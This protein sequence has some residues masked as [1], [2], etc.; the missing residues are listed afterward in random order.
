[1]SV[2]YKK[3]YKIWLLNISLLMCCYT[4]PQAYAQDNDKR[5][6][7]HYFL[8]HCRSAVDASLSSNRD[9]KLSLQG[10]LDWGYHIL[11]FRRFQKGLLKDQTGYAEPVG[12]DA[13]NT[14]VTLGVGI[15][16]PEKQL[17]YNTS[18]FQIEEQR[19]VVPIY[20]QCIWPDFFAGG[21]YTVITLGLQNKYLMA[22]S[23]N[24]TDSNPAIR[25]TFH[26][27]AGNL[28]DHCDLKSFSHSVCVSW[29]IMFT[30]G[31]YA[32]LAC[33]IPLPDPNVA[34][35]NKRIYLR[36]APPGVKK[37]WLSTTIR[38]RVGM[39][40][41]RLLKALQKSTSPKLNSTQEL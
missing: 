18:D 21:N 23:Y 1:M 20:L 39:D 14:L 38:L 41:A 10:G 27:S 8:D 13:G 17:L 24:S 12:I 31:L 22:A 15:R 40:I 2:M 3:S 36:S 28:R 35:Y 34:T 9:N 33:D 30:F 16:Y 26:Q 32:D 4:Q 37:N 7:G 19:L 5:H 25:E 11:K 29:G 6:P